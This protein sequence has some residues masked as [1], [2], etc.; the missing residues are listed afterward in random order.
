[1][2]RNLLW[3]LF[4][5]LL[6]TSKL[7]G[8]TGT[9]SLRGTVTDKSGGVI[10]GAKVTLRN[11]VRAVER[12]TT[13]GAAG[14]FEFPSLPPGTYSLAVE[15]TG[16][17]SYEQ[18][19]V[20][21]LV[22]SPASVNVIL[23]LGSATE[24]IE[25]TA[26][27]ET[28]NTSNASLGIAFNENQ[29]KQLPLEGRNV[30]DLLTLQAGVT[31][32]GNRPFQESRP[33][34]DTRNGAVNGAHSDQSNITLDGVDV[35]DETRGYAFKSVLPVTLD[36]VQEFRVTTTNYSADQGRSSGAQVS[37]VTKSGTNDFHGSLYEYLRNT[38]TSA[39][40]YFEKISES[41]N[42]EPNVPLKLIRNIFGGSV[43]GP[44][45]KDRLFFFANY[46][47]ARQREE[48]SI[49]R[50]V[51]S[52][53]LRDGVV[54]YQCD[55][56]SAC[57]G[58]TVQGLTGPHQIKP[59]YEGLTPQDVATL[60]PLHVGPNAA[61][62]KYFNTFPTTG[63]DTNQSD[64]VNFVGFRF[65]GP[66]PTTKN[67][68]IARLD[69]KLTSSGSHSIFWRG[70]LQ[71]EFHSE[72]PYLPGQGPQQSTADYSKGFAVGYTAVLRPDLVNNFRWG[73]TRQS[74]GSFGNSD[75]PFI[76]FRGLNDDTTSNNS[77]LQ[78]V[79]TNIFQV[80]V[81]NFVDD[82]S[83]IKGKH[84]LQFGVN[85][86]FLRTSRSNT[87]SSFSSGIANP[88]FLPTAGIANTGIQ[89]DPSAPLSGFPT[90]ASS[91]NTGYD[92]PF[93]ALLGSISQVNAN[94]NYTING[95]L[96]PQ[97]T[98]LARHFAA[99]SY[100]FYAQDSWKIKP[101]LT[102]TYGLRYSLSSPPWETN[103]VQVAPTINLGDWFN[104]RAQNMN[105]G[106]GSSVDPV[107]SL[108]L[109]G[110]A[111]GKPGFYDWDYHN[112][113]PRIG[114]A[115]APSASGG[116]W[117]KLLGGSGQSTV[118]A[119]FGIVYDR[120]GQG[121][122]STF[123]KRGSF[124]LLSEL[125]NSNG[126]EDLT[127]APRLTTDVNT[128]PVLDNLGNPIFT[129][130]PPGGFPQTPPFG[131]QNGAF[132]AANS[133]DASLK[134]PYSYALDLSVGR[135]LGHDFSI[136]ISYVGRLSHR[137]LALED[138]AQPADLVDPK[139]KV[140]YY[141][142][143]QALARLYEPGGDPSKGVPA[144]Q[145]TPAMVGPTAQYWY[146]MTQPLVAGGAYS[147]DAGTASFCAPSFNPTD[148]LQANYALF[149]CYAH[150]EST[151]IQV[152]DQAGFADP[153]N[154]G[155]AYHGNCG[156]TASI[157]N[158]YL[159]S[160]YVSLLAW[161]S[162][163]TASYHA[164]QV[165]IR[166]RLSKGVQFDLNYTYSK[167]IDLQSDA[168]R[169]DLSGAGALGFIQNAWRPKQLRG[170]SDFDTPHQI[171]ANWIIELP[172]GKGKWM[173]KNAGRSLDAAIGGW[174]LSGLARWTTGFPVNI[175]NGSAWPTNW[176][177]NPN[178][179]QVA[180]A[181]T[182][183]TKNPDGSVN[184]FPDPQ[185]PT[186]LGAFINTFPGESGTRNPIRG[187]GFT[188][189]DASLSKRWIMP[190]KDSQ[191]LQFRW[192]VF[193]VLNL[194]R[195]DVQTITSSIDL[196][197]FGNYSGLSTQPRVM[198]FALRFEF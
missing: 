96:L 20:Q 61:V 79:R 133:I 176:Q 88:N 7:A 137:L 163:G 22:D 182:K 12:T 118:R 93:M 47:G 8:Q 173:G 141:S 73:Y 68:Y 159:N 14:A 36:S 15:M 70:A 197:G 122:L 2:K 43:G 154:A 99:D 94:Y 111:H 153:N 143:V 189:L 59:G 144:T 179:T 119:G 19:S 13:T 136:E 4:A 115:W 131:S 166:K 35:N 28:L 139:S 62:L 142:A 156:A 113:G 158:C 42:G 193:N 170:V 186:G 104:L 121:V 10:Q 21:L 65:R 11:P 56:P 112:F 72:P 132:A 38:I 27:A 145:I 183:T 146:D 69:Y 53:A 33:D 30:P 67:W 152:L 101:N 108:D 6:L 123:D 175:G 126:G 26:Q 184:I 31:V 168:E 50:I 3:I 162:I 167:S 37:L 191:S 32:T 117:K 134:T 92:Y 151:A 149:S 165:N 148:A 64:G 87:L 51:P 16:F 17:R 172:F 135:E 91:F 171:N 60:D 66:A 161:R 150:N 95:T 58:G 109:A 41:Q 124:G 198:Q 138:M 164:L 5:F 106:I 187:D 81:H 155:V 71:N 174:Q 188:G 181:V 114:V 105:Q 140:D 48:H 97:G 84:T 125:T 120:V 40:D 78:V 34:V 127:T 157:P 177:F 190:W 9:T 160:Q 192:E 55:D 83:W 54:Q 185:G 147:L 102:V 44:V 100:E 196:G 75:Q 45:L 194:T 85:V 98:P 77:S 24:T 82:V 129:P 80:P 49:L 180:P 18:R 128:I 1:M 169:V 107:I 116:F 110:P 130:A 52:L 74:F 89:G 63:F 25:V 46:E 178:A 39:N 90:V 76:Q 29:V 103:G 195:F 57:P 86:E 23:E